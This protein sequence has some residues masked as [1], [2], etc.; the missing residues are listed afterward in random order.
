MKPVTTAPR[1]THA[2]RRTDRRPFSDRI[3]TIIDG[4]CTYAAIS[5]YCRGNAGAE[6][7]VLLDLADADRLSRWIEEGAGRRSIR[8]FDSSRC[9]HRRGLHDRPRLYCQIVDSSDGKVKSWY[10]H[11]WVLGATDPS[12]QVRHIDDCGLNNRRSNLVSGTPRDNALDAIANR[13]RGFGTTPEAVE[14]ELAAGAC[15]E[16]VADRL[17]VPVCTV[18]AIRRRAV[19][20]GRHFPRPKRRSRNVISASKGQPEV[21]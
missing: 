11:R 8:I 12:E 6:H 7:R 10:L 2:A 13:L 3:E 16:V 5:L 15:C 9:R 17:A 19:R 14:D 18:R 21:A 4:G 1:W 20:S